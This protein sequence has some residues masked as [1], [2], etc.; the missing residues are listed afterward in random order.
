MGYFKFKMARKEA[1]DTNLRQTLRQAILH[2]H[3]RERYY[4]HRRFLLAPAPAVALPPAPTRFI[5]SSSNPAS[6]RIF[7]TS[8]RIGLY[9]PKVK[10]TR[11][12]NNIQSRINRLGCTITFLCYGETIPPEQLPSVVARLMSL[13]SPVVLSITMAVRTGKE[14]RWHLSVLDR[15]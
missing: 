13:L 14:E 5:S 2:L 10:I 8:S 15:A 4:H 12:L 3:F 6:A 11:E 1:G 9:V 7:S